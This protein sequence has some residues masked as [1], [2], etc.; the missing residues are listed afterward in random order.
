[1]DT[2]YHARKSKERMLAILREDSDGGTTMHEKYIRKLFQ[3][4]LKSD[5]LM[6]T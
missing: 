6:L 4:I 1:M 5:S 2:G 3:V